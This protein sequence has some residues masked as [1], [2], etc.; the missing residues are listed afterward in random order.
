MYTKLKKRFIHNPETGESL[1]KFPQ[2]VM[3]SVIELDHQERERR[4]R[5]ERE[6]DVQSKEEGPGGKG[7]QA[8]AEIKDGPASASQGPS[9]ADVEAPDAND[10]DYDSDEYEEV[11]VTDDEDEGA[12]KR[13]K[14]E[15]DAQGPLEFD[16]DDI[17]YQLA[18]MGQDDEGGGDAYWEEDYAEE[19]PLNEEDATALFADLLEDFH[20]N[21]FKP[22]ESLVDE[23]KI[24]DD[25]RYTC[26]PTM[27]A[28][29]EAWSE[30]SRA[31]MQR[32]RE[33]K[34]QQEKTDP[35]IPYLQLLEERAT[36]K[37]YWPEFKRKFRKEPAM[38]DAKVGD[39]EREKW[40]RE[41]INRLKMPE[42]SL[43]AD[44]TALLKAQPLATL[45]RST[46]LEALPSAL[47]T[48]MRYVSVPARVRDPLIEAYIAIQPPAPEADGKDPED[49]ERYAKD[50]EERARRERALAEREQ[51]V[52]EQQRRNTAAK[53]HGREMLREEEGEVQR[54]MRVGREGLKSHVGGDD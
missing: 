52:R 4:E 44:L 20:I 26:L 33:Q 17:A 25:D 5:G 46:S 18:A 39:K 31:K 49:V 7:S 53:R 37:L 23:G 13:Q 10:K 3:M 24:I 50:K 11:V 35:R 54:A 27:K 51:R 15:S 6:E 30:W 2:D 21:P 34:L 22:W 40:Y 45:N 1:W 9:K 42:S 41:Y 29:K 8:Q 38:R 16:E 14:L 47:L 12:P 28:R 36:P 19:E 32:L 43:K 48:D